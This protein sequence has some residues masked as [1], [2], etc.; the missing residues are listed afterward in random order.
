[1]GVQALGYDTRFVRTV[2]HQIVS[3]VRGGEQVKM[4]TR[5]G[6]YV[7]LDELVDEVGPDP[8]VIL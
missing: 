3:L 5:R 7:T 1:M 2:L 8:S 4:S 6:T